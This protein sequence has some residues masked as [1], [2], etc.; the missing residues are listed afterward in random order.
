MTD[1]VTSADAGP[2]RDPDAPHFVDPDKEATVEIPF[3]HSDDTGQRWL[4]EI[5]NPPR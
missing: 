5:L 3:E 4:H 1:E 2:L